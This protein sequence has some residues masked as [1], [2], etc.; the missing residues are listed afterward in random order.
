MPSMESFVTGH[1]VYKDRW[2]PQIGEILAVR[3]YEGNRHDP[4]AIGVFKGNVLV[5]H[6][7]RCKKSDISSWLRTPA[8]RVRALV[9]GRRQNNRGRGLEVPVVYETYVVN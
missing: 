2:S 9:T 1:H 5:G 7:P 6:V 3:R 8:T 4:Y